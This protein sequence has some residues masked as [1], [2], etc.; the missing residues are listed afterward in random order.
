LSW[1]DY[2]PETFALFKEWIPKY[3]ND[4]SQ[5]KLTVSSSGLIEA[6]PMISQTEAMILEAWKQ[7][8]R[9]YDSYVS[10]DEDDFRKWVDSL[11]NL[12]D[13]LAEKIGTLNAYVSQLKAQRELAVTPVLTEEQRL[14]QL[15]LA[16][17]DKVPGLG[18]KRRD[19]LVNKFG[20]LEALRNA[21]LSEIRGVSGVGDSLG[22]DIWRAMQKVLKGEFRG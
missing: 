14:D 19:A 1:L 22:I 15:T 17:L 21:W 10:K 6:N 2:G 4:L 13:E 11:N 16:A 12:L 5:T 9:V 7:F 8:V 18:P 20:D 3:E